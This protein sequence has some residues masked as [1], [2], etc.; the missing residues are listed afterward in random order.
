MTS[1]EI[2]HWREA[3]S[4]RRFTEK[5]AAVLTEAGVPRMPARVFAALTVTD[6]GRLTAAEL[7]DILQVSAAAVSGA[8][9]YL[10]QVKL[11]SREHER[12]SRRD[13]YE[14]HDALWQEIILSRDQVL[15]RWIE[16]ARE[17]VE[18]LGRETPAGARMVETLAFYEFLHKEMPA[19]IDRWREYRADLRGEYP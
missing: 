5:Y 14:V 16:S 19:L 11:V 15:V 8:V 7:A 6:S 12:G 4:L 18:V 17:G 2:D 10:M 3:G 9:R 1:D 13:H